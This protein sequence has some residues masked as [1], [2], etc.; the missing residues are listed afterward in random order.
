MAPADHQHPPGHHPPKTE[1][2]GR[3]S[4]VNERI[5][6]ISKEKFGRRGHWSGGDKDAS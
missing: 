4:A 6:S 3:P 1:A 5:S 2:S